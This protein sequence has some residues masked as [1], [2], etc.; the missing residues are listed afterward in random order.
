ML[1]ILINYYWTHENK[2]VSIFLLPCGVSSNLLASFIVFTVL[3]LDARPLFGVFVLCVSDKAIYVALH[4]RW[5]ASASSLQD[6][7]QHIC[8]KNKDEDKDLFWRKNPNAHSKYQMVN[9]IIEFD[10]K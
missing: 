8:K 2:F 9:I 5:A 1:R 4:E 7:G 3:H 10:K 6:I